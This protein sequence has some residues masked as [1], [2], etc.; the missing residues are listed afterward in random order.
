MKT[1]RQTGRPPFQIDAKRLKELRGER[2]LT[3]KRLADAAYELAGRP[4]EREARTSVSS[5]QKVERTGRT[6]KAFA[7]ALAK[8]LGTSLA[9]LQ[10]EAPDEAP[11]AIDQIEQQLLAQA[12]QGMNTTLKERLNRRVDGLDNQS[13]GERI[14]SLAVH[15]SGRIEGVW[16]GQR[17]SE[18]AYLAELTG[19]PKER[20]REPL[21]IH[22]YWLLQDSIEAGRGAEII[23]GAGALLIRLQE[24]F[25]RIA[26]SLGSDAAISIHDELPWFYVDVDVGNPRIPR[27]HSFSFARCRSSK[28]GLQWVNPNWRDRMFLDE[29][30]MD[31]AWKS[32]NFVSGPN[33]RRLPSDVRRLRLLVQECGQDGRPERTVALVAGS[34]AD[35]G[36]LHE[37]VRESFR[38]RGRMHD[39][40]LE[41]LAH[42]LWDELQPL[43]SAWPLSAWNVR[44]MPMLFARAPGIEL[45]VDSPAHLAAP[46]GEQPS[47]RTRYMLPLVEEMDDEQFQAVPWRNASAEKLAAMLSDRL[48]AEA[49]RE[50]EGAQLLRQT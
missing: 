47:Y 42:G 26:V 11:E 32:V 7:E 25:D 12:A 2:Q 9:V 41:N 10:G 6:S 49:A 33:G 29:P 24:K 19:W 16:F 35:L 21:N 4:K 34:I 3:Q 18:L 36:Q 5:Y 48:A 46:R 40:V 8:V 37:S 20:L 44:C 17:P 15:I 30:L 13:E 22:G 23:L 39:L 28:S 43:L 50:R 27:R 31:W 1:S 38:E 45:I 14:H